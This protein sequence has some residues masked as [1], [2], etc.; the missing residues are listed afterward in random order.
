MVVTDN[1]NRDENPLAS[2]WT[3]VSGTSN[4]LFCTAALG[5]A[6]ANTAPAAM[7]YNAAFADDQYAQINAYSAGSAGSDVLVRVQSGANSYYASAWFGSTLLRIV[8]VTNGT[9][10]VLASFS[11][12]FVNG[13]LIRL[14]VSGSTLSLY[15]NGTLLGTAT[16]TTYTSGFPGIQVHTTTTNGADNFEAGDLGGG[17]GGSPTVKFFPSASGVGWAFPA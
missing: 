16:D 5:H 7:Y 4:T 12:S 15:Y 2:P 6:L 13:A 14:E 17:G 3:L 8:K 1:F 11:V 10:S 9:S